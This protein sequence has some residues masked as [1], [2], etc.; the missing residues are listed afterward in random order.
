ME[1]RADV[2]IACSA[3]VLIS[4]LIYQLGWRLGLREVTK[5]TRKPR[6]RM[7]VNE[8]NN[9]PEVIIVGSGILGSAMA[10]VLARD[11]RKVTVIERDMK[12]P[13]RIVGELFQPGGRQALT[14]LGLGDCASGFEEIRMD[15]FVIYDP[16]T[17]E[18]I[19]FQYPKDKAGKIQPAT[20]F[21]HGRFVMSLRKAAMAEENVTYIE[22]TV[23][24]IVEEKGRIVG[25]EYKKKGQ[26]EKEILRAPLTIVADGTF[27]KFRKQF[28]TASLDQM[29]KPT[30]YFIAFKLKE[31]FDFKAHHAEGLWCHSTPTIVYRI[32]PDTLRLMFDIDTSVQPKNPKQFIMETIYP[33]LPEHLK[34]MVG[35]AM[36]NDSVRIRIVP[37]YYIPSAPVQKPGCLLL[38][39]ALNCRHPY[40]A[41]GM[42]VAFKDVKCWADLLEGIESL[43]ESISKG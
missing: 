13:D 25:V 42:T 15:G 34:K 10:T 43:G 19:D 11:G 2:I 22:G 1:F 21:H 23:T 37:T 30:S 12:E 4:S 36:E 33:E 27:S 17:K 38:G 8:N 28:S 26:Q 31:S 6:R 7:K 29:T 20:C 3:V 9:G 16:I 5:K 24:T 18:P 35:P 32:A 14:E 39:D 40:T 41:S